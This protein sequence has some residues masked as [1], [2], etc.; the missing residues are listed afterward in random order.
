MAEPP[1]AVRLAEQRLMA[2]HTAAATATREHAH[3]IAEA[4]RGLA[5]ALRDGEPPLPVAPWLSPSD[6][7][8][9]NAAVIELGLPEQFRWTGE[10]LLALLRQLPDTLAGTLVERWATDSGAAWNC[11][12]MLQHDRQIDRLRDQLIAAQQAHRCW[13]H[14][15]PEVIPGG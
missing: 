1:M 3:R 6:L 13:E 11:R 14:D 5:Q 9:V 7:A 2:A 12:E 15:H 4:R 8:Q 10:Q